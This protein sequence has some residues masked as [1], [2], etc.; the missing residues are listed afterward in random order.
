MELSSMNDTYAS[1][2]ITTLT[3]PKRMRFVGRF[4]NTLGLIR[5]F[6]RKA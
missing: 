2:N 1:T 4:V 3:E 5:Y 6:S